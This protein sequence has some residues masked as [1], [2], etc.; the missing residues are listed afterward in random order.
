MDPFLFL[1][2]LNINTDI[3]I[4]CV[5]NTT[6]HPNSTMAQ[7]NVEL[8]NNTTDGGEILLFKKISSSEWKYDRIIEL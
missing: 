2:D 7:M 3:L 5:L 6:N 8:L 1:F 4:E